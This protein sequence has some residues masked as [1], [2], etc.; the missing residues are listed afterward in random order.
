MVLRIV[1]VVFF[2]R[3][4]GYHRDSLFFFVRGVG[5]VRIEVRGR[6]PLFRILVG[7]DGLSLFLQEVLVPAFP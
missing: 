7:E 1:L 3:S 6:L 4:N 5:V 2:H